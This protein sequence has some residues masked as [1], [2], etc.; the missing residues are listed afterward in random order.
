M[1]NSIELK[2]MRSDLISKLE[3]IKEVATNEERDLTND[4]N[5][6]MDGILT[7]VDDIDT[8]IVRAEKVE[9]SIRESALVSGASVNNDIKDTKEVRD[10]SFKMLCVQL[11]LVKF[12][13]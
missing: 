13:V 6:E 3:V 1:K 2:E 11:T 10:Y 7:K 5:T 4:E 12:L 9:K 8:K